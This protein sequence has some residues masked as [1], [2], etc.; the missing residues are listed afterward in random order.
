MNFL[1]YTANLHLTL[2]NYSKDFPLYSQ[3]WKKEQIFFA[4]ISV[5]GSKY[6]F[7]FT[8]YDQETKIWFWIGCVDYAEWGYVSI[9]ELEESAKK[10]NYIFAIETWPFLLSDFEGYL[11]DNYDCLF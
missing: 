6:E 4:K 8:E 2:K 5:I 10:Y 7:Y 11:K 1:I 9:Q 3:D